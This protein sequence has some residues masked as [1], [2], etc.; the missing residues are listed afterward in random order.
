M[1]LTYLRR[2]LRRLSRS[3]VAAASC[4]GGWFVAGDAGARQLTM[5]RTPS[6]RLGH[7][8]SVSEPQ[9]RSAR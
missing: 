6:L 7:R 2:E 3:A 5:S 8:T 4:Q 1:L 9:D